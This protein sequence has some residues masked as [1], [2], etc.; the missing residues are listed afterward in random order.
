MPNDLLHLAKR[1]EALP[2]EIA[3]AASR[4]AVNVAIR[5]TESLVQGTPVDTS[6]ALSNWRV[7]LG[8]PIMG[9]RGAYVP[10]DFGSTQAVSA[11]LAIANAVAVL[12]NKKP[13]EPIYIVNNL[14]YIVDLDNG[15]ISKQ[16]GAFT[17]RA[18]VIG[19][20]EAQIFKL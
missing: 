12:T 10:G 3:R 4:T 14:D 17:A 15:T 19:R 6:Q 20:R 13:G 11:Q 8:H 7:S 16:P 2:G 9:T 1:M 5:V 18:L